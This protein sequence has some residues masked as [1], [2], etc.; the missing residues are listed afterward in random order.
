M[1][2]ITMQVQKDNEEAAT[3]TVKIHD[4]DWPV[5][6]LWANKY[7]PDREVVDGKPVDDRWHVIDVIE[8]WVRGGWKMVASQLGQQQADAALEAK[9]AEATARTEVIDEGK[10]A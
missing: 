8:N 3:R 10:K 9:I 7:F 1:Y 4:A 2:I 6:A 5:I